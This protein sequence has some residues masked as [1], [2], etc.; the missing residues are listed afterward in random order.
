[1]RYLLI[2][3]GLLPLFAVGQVIYSQNFD[4]FQVG[5]K[6]AAAD[7]A[8]WRT[9]SNPPGPTEDAPIT[10]SVSQSGPN[11][12]S[13][14]QTVFADSSAP[15]DVVLLLGYHLAGQYVLSW[16]MYIHDDGG[17]LITM[18]HTDDVPSAAPAAVLAY[19][20]AG[21]MDLGMMEV[22]ADGAVFT[23]Y[24]PRN[25]W[26]HVQFEFDLDGSQA[27]FAIDTSQ[28]A[29]WT[30]NT[31]P[32]GISAPN[33]LGA[34]RYEAYCGSWLC[35][36]R[37]HIDD[38]LFQAGTVGISEIVRANLLAMA[39]NPTAGNTLLS[40]NAPLA[41]GAVEVHDAS[42]RMVLQR[43]W[44]AG[45]S[46]YTLEA[47][48]LAPGTYMMRVASSTSASASASTLYSGKLIILP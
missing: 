36:G 42:G 11:S 27:T 8:N 10:D 40:V 7:P 37:Y 26:F 30:F 4:S 16:N 3:S 34:L 47:G 45:S 20:P 18:Y 9:W 43:A 21:N 22:Y 1:M 39:P 2:L 46:S 31:M 25:T 12:L 38:V 14:I 35:P 15:R 28:V 41:N 13:F 23:G 24:Y 6:I 48:A 32:S 33:I 19:Y 29:A 44:P 5:Q 17:A